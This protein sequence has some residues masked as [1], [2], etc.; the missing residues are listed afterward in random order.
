MGALLTREQLA[1]CF[2]FCHVD[3]HP[4]RPACDGADAYRQGAKLTANHRRALLIGRLAAL[5][6][7]ARE[8]DR[9]LVEL[10]IA[11]DCLLQR[12]RLERVEIVGIGPFQP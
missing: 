12:F 9:A 1:R 11:R 5:D 3:G 6:H 10:Q 8:F 7:P 4:S 2:H